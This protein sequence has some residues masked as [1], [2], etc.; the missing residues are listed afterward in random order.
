MK[1]VR[2][3]FLQLLLIAKNFLKHAFTLLTVRTIAEFLQKCIVTLTN[4]NTLSPESTCQP[5]ISLFP[6]FGLCICISAKRIVGLK[7]QS[8]CHPSFLNCRLSLSVSNPHTL[9]HTRSPFSL[10]I[11]AIIHTHHFVSVSEGSSG[12]DSL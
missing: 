1:P 7:A 12:K 9:T 3:N 4:V 11:H 10:Q 5:V 6:F 2:C 8:L